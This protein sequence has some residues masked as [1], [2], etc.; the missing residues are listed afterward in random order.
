MRYLEVIY[1]HTEILIS[2]SICP[3]VLP[4]KVSAYFYQY[5]NNKP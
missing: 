3:G 5:L 1:L 2:S 4:A